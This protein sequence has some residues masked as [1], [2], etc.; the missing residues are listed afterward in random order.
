[1]VY[2][3]YFVKSILPGAIIGSFQ[4]FVNIYFSKSVCIQFAAGSNSKSYLLQ[5][6][7][8]PANDHENAAKCSPIKK[9]AYK[10]KRNI[11]YHYQI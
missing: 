8:L 4:H 2:T 11:A 5:S 6:F 7:I 1:M 9:M 10:K 3:V